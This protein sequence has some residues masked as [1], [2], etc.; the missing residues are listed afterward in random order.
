MEDESD[1]V[2]GVITN[3][4]CIHYIACHRD[5]VPQEQL[6]VLLRLPFGEVEPKMDELKVRTPGGYV[7]TDGGDR[8]YEY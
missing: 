1:I 4:L 8:E 3:S 5:E 7:W 2:R 6:D